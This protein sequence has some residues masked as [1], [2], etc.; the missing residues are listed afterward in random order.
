[1]SEEKGIHYRIGGKLTHAGCE[2]LP[3][4]K[5]IPYIVIAKIEYKESEEVGGRT[6]KGVWIATFAPNPYTKLPMVLNSTNRKRIAKRSGTE[7]INL[8]K[9]IAVRL[10]KEKC[11]DVHDGG[12]TWGLRISKSDPVQPQTQS[13]GQTQTSEA[14]KP[15]LDERHPRWAECVEYIKKGNTVDALRTKYEVSEET[16]QKLQA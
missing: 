12:E 3:D 15:I 10:T 16:A 4:G 6:E 7:T 14:K 1:M 13:Q 9:N 8:V 5:D 11:R 2:I